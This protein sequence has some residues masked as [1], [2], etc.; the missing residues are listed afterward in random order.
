MA[1][2]FVRFH[3]P[4]RLVSWQVVSTASIA[5]F[6]RTGSHAMVWSSI[7]QTSTTPPFGWMGSYGV[8]CVVLKHV[9]SSWLWC[10]L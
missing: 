1:W 6:A 10:H 2:V 4:P 8:F 3:T 7:N 9:V 5:A